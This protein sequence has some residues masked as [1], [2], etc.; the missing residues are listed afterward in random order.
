M[1]SSGYS[2]KQNKDSKQTQLSSS[3]RGANFKKLVTWFEIPAFDFERAVQ[4]YNHIYDMTME[5]S[6]VNGYQMA[7]FPSRKGLN[8]AILC[9]EGSIP[10]DK[11]PLL[12]LN[13]IQ[14]LENMLLKIEEAGGKVL[15]GK[16]PISED[17]G[18]F[19]LFL[20]TEGN[21]LA[22]HEK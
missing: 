14:G 2:R 9:G 3:N 1:G 5:K 4:F 13:A 15:L 17:A 12:Y 10:S 20:D 11:G 22:L 18:S 7:L 8:G 21:K 6:E 19:A 16:T